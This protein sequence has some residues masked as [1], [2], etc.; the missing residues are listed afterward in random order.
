ML[1]NTRGGAPAAMMIGPK[2]VAL[3][4]SVLVVFFWNL[5]I[6]LPYDEFVDAAGI[7]ANRTFHAS[8]ATN[9]KN[10]NAMLEIVNSNNVSDELVDGFV[11]S[12]VAMA[13][14]I[15]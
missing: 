8:V 15:C 4:L 12:G 7:D 3:W 11:L 14:S 1:K 6:P 13:F 2:S 10:S 9:G 5:F